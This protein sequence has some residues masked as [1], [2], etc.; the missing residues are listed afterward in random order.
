[1]AEDIDLRLARAED[2]AAVLA[3]IHRAFAQYDG[4]LAPP[5]GAMSETTVTVATRLADENCVLA[6]AGSTPVGCV[7]YKEVGAAKLDKALLA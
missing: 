7:F 1:M 6:Y 5:S 3:V 2:A 4:I